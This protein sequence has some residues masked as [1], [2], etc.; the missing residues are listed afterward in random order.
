MPRST[1]RAVQTDLKPSVGRVSAAL[2][3]AVVLLDGATGECELDCGRMPTVPRR[4]GPSEAAKVAA[5]FRDIVSNRHP[6]RP[7]DAG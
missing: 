1:T 5:F 4:G 2:E 7:D 3:V 6:D